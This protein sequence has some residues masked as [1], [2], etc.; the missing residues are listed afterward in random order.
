MILR[1]YRV[2]LDGLGNEIAQVRKAD[3][4]VVDSLP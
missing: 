3:N 1:P 4:R 2:L